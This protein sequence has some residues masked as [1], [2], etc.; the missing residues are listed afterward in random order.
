MST[1]T[2]NL[3]RSLTT[4]MNRKISDADNAAQN[5]M[6]RAFSTKRPQEKVAFRP[7]I[8]LPIELLSATNP[9]AFTAPDIH[10]QT[11]SGVSTSKLPY[12]PA[13]TLASTASSGSLRS[14][15]SMP[16]LSTSSSVGSPSPLQTP[17]NEVA[18]RDFST[19]KRLTILSEVIDAGA[20][21][22]AKLE[23]SL[24]ANAVLDEDKLASEAPVVPKRAPS[25][26]KK[27]HQGLHRQ[28]S[29]S[30]IGARSASAT[31]P[32]SSS[33]TSTVS[34]AENESRKSSSS[35]QSNGR[36]STKSLEK[37][38]DGVKVVRNSIDI[39]SAG[40]SSQEHPFG[41]E[42]A[43]LDEMAEEF[44]PT[45]AKHDEEP[46]QGLRRERSF[47][48]L[49]R[50]LSRRDKK[51]SQQEKTESETEATAGL[52]RQ[53]SFKVLRRDPSTKELKAEDDNMTPKLEKAAQPV[54]E[55]PISVA[56][57][58]TSRR[59]AAT[60]NKDEQ[61]VVASSRTLSQTRAARH[62]PTKVAVPPSEP[63]IW[64]EESEYLD[65]HGLKP[66]S[67]EDYIVEIG[68]PFEST[69][70][71]SQTAWL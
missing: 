5:L 48:A 64:D 61:P 35:A 52:Q 7:E 24:A 37:D 70:S 66:Y 46:K 20:N 56:S 25:H 2:S 53:R 62:R 38:A 47:K 15:N 14:D 33:G 12:S 36:F 71:S 50:G 4:R 41:A 39:F 42:L 31:G 17:V 67:A 18:E 58:D 51:Q 6:S 54:H 32:R 68:S 8:S 69:F 26:T 22:A 63:T 65:K 21:I 40:E 27:A 34:M 30:R 3:A 29:L 28:R 45:K 10:P 19:E 57:R 43:K 59:R 11:A 44:S 60:I 9:L 1:T 16:G 13:Q 23:E 49:R 55:E